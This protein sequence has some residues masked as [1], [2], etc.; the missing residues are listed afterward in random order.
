MIWTC[1]ILIFIY[2]LITIQLL[3]Y[4]IGRNIL[5]NGF[6]PAATHS[7]RLLCFLRT[8]ASWLYQ[9]MTGLPRFGLSSGYNVVLFVDFRNPHIKYPSR[10][11]ILLHTN[12]M[13]EPTQLLN[14]NTLHNVYFHWI[15]CVN[16]CQ[17]ALDQRSY[18]GLF[19]RI[20][21]RMLHQCK[22]MS[23]FGSY[24]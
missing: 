22:T 5:I 6:R 23:R 11:S 4:L 19:S 18:V 7:S 14:I 8:Y 21:S 10:Q 13:A 1:N 12:D 16:H 3:T 24:L 2:L 17:L 20:L 9:S 15:E